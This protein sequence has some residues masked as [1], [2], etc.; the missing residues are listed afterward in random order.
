MRIFTILW[1]GTALTTLAT[2]VHA[3]HVPTYVV[4][5]VE[6]L[7]KSIIPVAITMQPESEGSSQKTWT[8]VFVI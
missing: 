2:A 4:T 1:L 5:D 7:A 6:T 8:I 3:D